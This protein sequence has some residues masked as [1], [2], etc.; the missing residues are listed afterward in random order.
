MSI[1]QNSS[2]DSTQA[3]INAEQQAYGQA[4]QYMMPY[5]QDAGQDFN[6]ARSWLY[7]SLGNRTNAYNQQFLSYLGM[8]PSALL[9]QAMS[10]YSMSPMAQQQMAVTNSG[11]NNAAAAAGMSGSGV[12]MGAEGEMDNAIGNQDIDHYLNQLMGALGLQGH[13][14]GA[15]DKETQNMMDMFQDML[16]TEN[17]AST[18]MANNAMQEGQVISNSENHQA[19]NDLRSSEDNRRT[20]DNMMSNILR[21]GAMGFMLGSKL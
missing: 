12:E 14:T 2:D 3:G 1:F 15:Y 11:V 6:N 20:L 19:S 5:T 8:S 9:G 18:G 21:G 16:G 4:Q 7:Q 13:I 17:K 10:S